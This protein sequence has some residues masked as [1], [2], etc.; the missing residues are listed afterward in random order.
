METSQP[1]PTQQPQTS[2]MAIASLITGILGISPLA[3]VFGHIAMSQIRKS[4]GQLTGF[5]LALAGTIIGYVGLAVII[6]LTAMSFLFVGARAWK[7]GSDRAACIMN[8]R[9]VQQTVRANA[10]MKSLSVGD[11]INWDE[12][13]GPGGYFPSEPVCPAGGTYTFT[14]T[15]PPTGTLVGQCSHADHVPKNHSDW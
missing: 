5:G 6:L 8:T 12:I 15:I 13:F 7:R 3:I 14:H 2:G 9:N 4:A 11:P 1:Y 10:N